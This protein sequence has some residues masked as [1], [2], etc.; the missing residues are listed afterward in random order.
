MPHLITALHVLGNEDVIP[1]LP[2][3]LIPS[4]WRIASVQGRRG[5]QIRRGEVGRRGRQVGVA[6]TGAVRIVHLSEKALF[7][8]RRHS[9][10]LTR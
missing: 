10:F 2:L 3:P 4:R 5:V 6:R 7:K 1:A 9:L 8:K